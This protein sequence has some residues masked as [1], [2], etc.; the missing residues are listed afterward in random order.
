MRVRSIDK[1]NDWTL[2]RGRNN[3]QRDKSALLQSL[4]TRLQSFLGD[5][6]F[7]QTEGIDWFG[8]AGSKR[9]TELALAISAVIL[10]TPEVTRIVDFDFEFKKDRTFVVTYNVESIYGNIEGSAN[11]FG[12]I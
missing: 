3:Y 12:E 6:F 2:G 1:D 9:Q 8:L 5:C 4:Q 10:N 11:P 7:A